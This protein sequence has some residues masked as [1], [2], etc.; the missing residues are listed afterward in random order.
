G[1]G[2]ATGHAYQKAGGYTTTVTVTDAAGQ[3]ITASRTL[4]IATGSASPSGI[5]FQC[6]LR[7]PIASLLLIGLPVGLTLALVFVTFA[8]RRSKRKR[9]LRLS[10]SPE[11][12][13]DRPG[14]HGKPVAC[15]VDTR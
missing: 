3:K 2:Q 13:D 4:A 11:S 7:N 5:C 6:L 14:R 8:R 1:T 9:L 12:T 10:S 15:G